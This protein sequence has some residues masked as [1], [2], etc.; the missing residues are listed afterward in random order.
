MF[1]NIERSG[2]DGEFAVERPGGRLFCVGFPGNVNFEGT[3]EAIASEI[4]QDAADG[5]PVLPGFP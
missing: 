5:Q 4:L 3:F 2:A 1:R